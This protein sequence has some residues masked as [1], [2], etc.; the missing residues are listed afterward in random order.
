M[1]VE[2][3]LKVGRRFLVRRAEVV[4][5]EPRVAF[6]E[7]SGRQSHRQNAQARRAHRSARA[8]TVQQDDW[9][10]E[11]QSVPDLHLAVRPV[12]DVDRKKENE[13]CRPLDALEHPLLGEVGRAIVIPHLRAQTDERSTERKKAQQSDAL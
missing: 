7:H 10:L 12:Q 11:R 3:R 6:C 1:L 9:L 8:L 4:A 5:A 13:G 2:Q